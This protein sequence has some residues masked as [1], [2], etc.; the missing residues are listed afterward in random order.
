MISGRH[1]LAATAQLTKL[2]TAT[3]K[4]PRSA[5]RTKPKAGA[6][7]ASPPKASPAARARK[8]EASRK[9]PGR[10]VE[11]DRICGEHSRAILSEAGYD[12]ATID[13]FFATGVVR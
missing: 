3:A 1:A 6:A 8:A 2:L 13:G 9:A 7:K 11:I 5:V 12:E 10:F 4:P